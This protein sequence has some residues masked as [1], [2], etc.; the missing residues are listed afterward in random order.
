MRWRR[1]IPAGSDRLDWAATSH[2][3]PITGPASC[4]NVN[5]QIR[6]VTDDLGRVRRGSAG[7]VGPAGPAGPA[8][9]RRQNGAG[10]VP[11]TAILSISS[12]GTALGSA[13]SSVC[14]APGS[15]MILNARPAASRDRGGAASSVAAPP[16]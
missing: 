16:R 5:V 8:S 9:G 7:P 15:L 3:V 11:S 4:E 14:P 1:P 10:L 13:D 12:G 2:V 6:G